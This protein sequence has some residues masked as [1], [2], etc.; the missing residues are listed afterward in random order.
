M[1]VTNLL[2]REIKKH[3]KINLRSKKKQLKDK[4]KNI[5]SK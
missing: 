3:S 1:L 2:K 4:I 5:K